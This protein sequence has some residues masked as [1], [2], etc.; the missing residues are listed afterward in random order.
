MHTSADKLD[1]LDL[2]ERFIVAGVWIPL[3]L[4]MIFS[5]IGTGLQIN[6]ISLIL[7]LIT[8]VALI[9]IGNGL[10]RGDRRYLS[11]AA[12]WAA[13]MGV[14]GLIVLGMVLSTPRTLA[15]MGLPSPMACWILALGCFSQVVLGL[16]LFVPRSA[17]AY[18]AHKRGEE[19]VEEP[20]AVPDAEV[21]TLADARVQLMPEAKADL[22][23][24]AGYLLTAGLGLIGLAG[25][26][27]VGG[28]LLLYF[29]GSGWSLLLVGIFAFLLGNILRTPAEDLRYLTQTSGAETPHLTNTVNGLGF[30]LKYQLGV[31]ALL[32]VV[33]LLKLTL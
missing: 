31:G 15:S 25:L 11:F 5:I 2:G 32:A 20:E 28:A 10:H 24:L 12:G 29:M 9:W 16:F 7:G 3:G 4:G 6:A 27:I 13:L 22:G 26:C 19:Y 17:M 18:M 23:G 21:F 1:R 14:I 8:P 33:L 30:F